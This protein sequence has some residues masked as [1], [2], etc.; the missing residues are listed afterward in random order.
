MIM[1]W[2][3]GISNDVRGRDSLKGLGESVTRSPVG[4]SFSAAAPGC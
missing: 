1:I 4:F 2:A 3:N